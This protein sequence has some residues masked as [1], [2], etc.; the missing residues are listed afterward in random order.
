MPLS[1]DGGAQAPPRWRPP[2]IG[3][4]PRPVLGRVGVPS[5]GVSGGLA[6]GACALGREGGKPPPHHRTCATAPRTRPPP[7]SPSLSHLFSPSTK[8]K[9]T[10]QD[11]EARIA[12]VIEE[13][14]ATLMERTEL[15]M[16]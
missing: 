16:G 11:V 13:Y 5:E 2:P 12:K 7:L 14:K 9:N 4:P 6:G 1:P 15:H 10:F 8:N 3:R